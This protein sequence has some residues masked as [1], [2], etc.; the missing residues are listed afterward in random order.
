VRAV[1]VGAD[2]DNTAAESVGWVKALTWT[3]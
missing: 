3:R 2:S 1:L